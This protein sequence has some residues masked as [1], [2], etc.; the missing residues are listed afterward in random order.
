MS[1]LMKNFLKNLN[2]MLLQPTEY[3]KKIEVPRRG[4]ILKLLL[5][6][7]LLRLATLLSDSY[8][9]HVTFDTTLISQHLLDTF[10]YL[11]VILLLIF[12][13]TL[14]YFLVLKLWRIKLSFKK[15]YQQFTYLNLITFILLRVFNLLIALVLFFPLASNNTIIAQAN[16]LNQAL[17][18]SFAVWIALYLVKIIN[19]QTKLTEDRSILILISYLLVHVYFF[20]L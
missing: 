11:L 8:F 16:N 20:G 18:L 13:A 3:L 12:I 4:K 2:L 17:A 19:Y 5:L 14:I 15:F 1:H 9:E 6:L 7:A 10:L